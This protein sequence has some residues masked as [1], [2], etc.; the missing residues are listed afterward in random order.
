MLA[1][2]IRCYLQLEKYIKLLAR[3]CL[4]ISKRT[5]TIQT[6][7]LFTVENRTFSMS[8][9]THG[10]HKNIKKYEQKKDYKK[11]HF[12]ESLEYYTILKF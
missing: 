11:V 12:G 10:T 3:L 7:P 5:K 9:Q 2:F 4:E 8:T 6:Q 1:I